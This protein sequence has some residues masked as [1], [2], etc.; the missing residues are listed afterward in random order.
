MD[1]LNRTNTDDTQRLVDP[2]PLSFSWGGLYSR[3]FHLF[4]QYTHSFL[5]WFATRIQSFVLIYVVV[6]V[7]EKSPWKHFGSHALCQY[8]VGCCFFRTE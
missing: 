5:I 4:F 3:W 8:P 6:S 2:S 7:M 1:K